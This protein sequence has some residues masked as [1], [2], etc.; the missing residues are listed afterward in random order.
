MA[1]LILFR[2]Q[3]IKKHLV[4][5]EE[6]LGGVFPPEWEM[7]ERIA[8]HACELTRKQL[9]DLMAL[10]YMALVNMFSLLTTSHKTGR[11]TSGYIIF[12]LCASYCPLRV[13]SSD[14]LL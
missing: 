13:L 12:T 11:R 3:W 14:L 1:F 7:T 6:T 5:F 2:Y 8:V 10:R 9:A 4:Y